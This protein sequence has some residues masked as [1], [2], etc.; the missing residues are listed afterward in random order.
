MSRLAPGHRDAPHEQN[1]FFPPVVG[2]SLEQR[3]AFAATAPYTE[4]V[5]FFQWMRGMGVAA[6][7]S[8]FK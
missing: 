1:A 6:P 5:S 3:R 8:A 2:T 4:E 7:L